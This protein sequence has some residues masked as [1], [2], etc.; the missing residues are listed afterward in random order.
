MYNEA[1]ET[2]RAG[3]GESEMGGAG[4]AKGRRR[5]RTKGDVFKDSPAGET[6]LRHEVGGESLLRPGQ[7][8][9]KYIGVDMFE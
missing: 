1:V 3:V 9:R 4:T 5:F 8:W 7:C 6:A 2:E